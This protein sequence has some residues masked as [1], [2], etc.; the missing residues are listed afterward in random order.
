MPI[1]YEKACDLQEQVNE[2]AVILFPHV[3]LDSVICLR[4]HGSSSRGTIARCHALGRAMQLAL[5]RKGF[6]VIEVISKR[7]DKM[8]E[9][10]KIKT[11][12]HELM[13]IP[14]SFGGGFIHH[15]IVHEA[16]V[17]RMYEKYICLKKTVNN[18]R[19]LKEY[20]SDNL[21]GDEDKSEENSRD[22]DEF[23]I[24]KPRRGF[25]F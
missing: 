8:S 4:S 15:N 9:E 1:R 17:E 13:H 22:I 21:M 10:D 18:N 11:L 23:I 3:R 19:S 24:K 12:I 25:W 20:S 14:K 7:F 6:Y 16:N 2:I 5:G